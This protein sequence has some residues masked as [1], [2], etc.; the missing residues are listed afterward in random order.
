MLLKNFKTTY[1]GIL[2]QAEII[3]LTF[4]CKIRT[5]FLVKPVARILISRFRKK[6]KIKKKRYVLVGWGSNCPLKLKLAVTSIN[7]FSDEENMKKTLSIISKEN[8]PIRIW[9]L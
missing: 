3:N 8:I 1:K 5:N 9:I 7:R 2:I 4:R 6:G